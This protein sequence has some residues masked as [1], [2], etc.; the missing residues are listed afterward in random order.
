MTASFNCQMGRGRT[1]TG[2]V[3][4]SLIATITTEDMTLESVADLDDYESHDEDG[5]TAEAT[6]FLNGKSPT[7]TLR[8]A[9][10]SQESTRRSCSSSLCSRMGSVSPSAVEEQKLLT[11]G[12]EAKRITDKVINLMEGVQN[13]RKAIY[14]WV[15]KMFLNLREHKLNC[16]C[17][18]KLK[19]DAAEVGSAKHSAILRQATNYLYR[20]ALN[21]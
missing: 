8:R 2:M 7:L 19:V 10:M 11:L 3:A 17:S 13:L 4:A 5:M 18:Y 16:E 9:D 21:S 15:Q 14:E 20:C 6:Q 1:T 12:S